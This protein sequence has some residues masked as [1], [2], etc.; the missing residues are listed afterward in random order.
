M[1]ACC[2]FSS[3]SCIASVTFCCLSSRAE[4]RKFLPKIDKKSLTINYEKTVADCLIKY[5]KEKIEGMP[6]P[7]DCDKGEFDTPYDYLY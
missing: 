6:E 5:L 4:V 7:K 2:S 1:L 3:A